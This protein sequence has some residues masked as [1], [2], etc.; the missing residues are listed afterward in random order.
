MQ[1]GKALQAG[2]SHFLGQN[3][4]K[5]FDVKFLNQKGELEYV[6]ATS[7]GVSTRLIGAIIMTHSDNNGLVL[8]PAISP[9][10]VVIVPIYKSVDEKFEIMNY[11]NN[12]FN[13][14][15]QHNITVKFDDRDTHKPGWKFA[16]YELKGIPIR[17]AVGPKDIENNQVEIARRDTLE[18]FFI[19]RT[20]LI[21]KIKQLLADIQNNIYQ[22][23]LTFR[24]NNTYIIDSLKDLYE[25]I[26]KGGFFVA[27]WEGT[28]EHEKQ[29]NE[30]TKATIRCIPFDEEEK[31]GKCIVTGILTKKRVIIAK[32]Y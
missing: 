31:L 12:I 10:H 21:P 26:D 25:N 13:E 20:E 1:D 18:K 9:L 16:E 19:S 24:N 32:A 28:K 22:K 2:T 29:L 11:C 6:W 15:K 23:A 5:A 4:A 14:I 17:I 30:Q 8:P 7:W 27:H 3:F